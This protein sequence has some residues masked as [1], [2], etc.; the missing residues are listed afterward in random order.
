MPVA[1]IPNATHYTLAVNPM[2]PEV[3]DGFLAAGVVE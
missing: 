1:V 3:V 2:L